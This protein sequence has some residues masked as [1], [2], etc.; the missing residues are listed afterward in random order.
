VGVEPASL[1]SE[2]RLGLFWFVATDRKASRFAS[3]SRSFNEVAE[4]GGFKT[5]DEGHVDVW[6]KLKR[7]HQALVP[8][9]YEH[10]PRG[11][12]N[13]RKEDD[14]WILLLDPK[15]NSDPFI[16]HVTNTWS[17]PRNRLLVLTDAHYRS[18]AHVGPLLAEDNEFRV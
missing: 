10:F 13:W 4:I 16:A 8:Y 3:L 5:L 2:S 14:K 12:V 7:L 17:L 9:E 15:L 6:L 11:R 1:S 18:V